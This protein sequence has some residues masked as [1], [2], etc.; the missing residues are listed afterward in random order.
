MF[1]LIPK[2]IFFFHLILKEVKTSL[3]IPKST[4]PTTQWS[5]HLM[6]KSALLKPRSPSLHSTNT[7]PR[8]R[9]GL[10]QGHKAGCQLTRTPISCLLETGNRVFPEGVWYEPWH[11]L[12][13]NPASLA[14]IYPKPRLCTR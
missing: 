11:Y 12:E 6:E 3:W 7:K 9:Q 4:I 8:D 13:M 1:Y 2:L 14:P 10:A 5:L